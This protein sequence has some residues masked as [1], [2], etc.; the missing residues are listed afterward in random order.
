M[1]IK[2]AIVNYLTNLDIDYQEA[3]KLSEEYSIIFSIFGEDIIELKNICERLKIKLDVLI[4]S[5]LTSIKCVQSEEE[6]RPVSTGFII[7]KYEDINILLKTSIITISDKINVKEWERLRQFCGDVN[8]ITNVFVVDKDNGFIIDIKKLRNNMKDYENYKY[9][10]NKFADVIGIQVI[11]IGSCIN[12]FMEGDVT[13]QVLLI[14]KHGNWTLRKWH[15]V[16]L[17]IKDVISEQTILDK[18]LD[19]SD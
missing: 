17:I 19:A 12:I 4:W 1:S 9:V 16:K 13:Y 3:K 18:I 5:L 15:D 8:G 7:G 10:T 14:R 2:E 11:G 6:S